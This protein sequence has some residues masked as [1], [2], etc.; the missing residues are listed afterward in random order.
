MVK[1][2]T[3]ALEVAQH[4][5]SRTECFAC[6][7]W[8]TCKGGCKVLANTHIAKN[9]VECAGFKTFLNYVKEQAL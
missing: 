8:T 5:R 3:Y 9:S 7:F 2:D 4:N 1:P 6:E